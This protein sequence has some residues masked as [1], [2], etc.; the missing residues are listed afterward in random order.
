M[1][2][3]NAVSTTEGRVMLL[4]EMSS[5]LMPL[6]YSLQGFYILIILNKP[7]KTALV[8]TLGTVSQLI[9]I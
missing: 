9:N 6:I 2:S 4:P 7:W 5:K 3:D 1:W 8:N